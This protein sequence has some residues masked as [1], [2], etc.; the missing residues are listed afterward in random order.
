MFKHQI[1][2]EDQ[3]A[4][5][6]DLAEHDEHIVA[7]ETLLLQL[8]GVKQTLPEEVRALAANLQSHI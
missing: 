2:S 7:C 1:I 8:E 3:L 6:H 4:I 5:N